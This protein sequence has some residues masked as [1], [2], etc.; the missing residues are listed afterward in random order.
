MSKECVFKCLCCE[1]INSKTK[2]ENFSA[3]PVSLVQKLRREGYKGLIY[4][5]N[6]MVP[7][8]SVD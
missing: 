1:L 5:Y 6:I 3:R 7:V 8:R 2:T 4:V